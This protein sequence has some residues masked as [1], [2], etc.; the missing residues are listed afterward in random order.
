MK[1]LVP[2]YYKDFKCIADDCEDTCCA[3]WQ[4]DV[5]DASYAYYKTI[6]GDFGDRLHSVMVDGTNGREGQFRIREDGRCPFLNDNNLCDLYA[7]L[8]EDALCVTCDRYPRYTCEFGNYRETG[9]A[10]SCKTAAE[11][12]L[13]GNQTPG[14]ILSENDESFGQLNN[15][16][17]MLFLNL[18]KARQKA[19]SIVWD[20]KYTIWE[21]MAQLLDYAEGLQKVI[22]KPDRLEKYIKSYKAKEIPKDK[23]LTEKQEIKY[24]HVIW[25]Y[26][27]KQVII[28]M[29]WP[30]L[31]KIIQE[32]LYLGDY[33]KETEAFAKYYKSKEYEY[34]NLITYFIF[35]YFL[36]AVFDNDVLTKVK[37]GIVSVLL[38]R[39]CDIGTWINKER[40]LNFKEQVD[41][42]HLY[43]REVEHSEENFAALCKLFKTKK[44]FKNKN[45]IKLIK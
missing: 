15:I 16:D 31:V 34:E 9:I 7:E 40:V 24:Y 10:L 8:G 26:Y 32:N 20:K 39:Q 45:L 2:D 11:L 22:R 17:G 12:I 30:H 38:I 25:K 4:V 43:S 19:F 44:E 13:K 37:M 35:R 42:C 36:K 6:T 3:G 28:K 33:T 5:D 29:E 27:M 23:Q 1:I 14:F 18:K 41:I 21:R